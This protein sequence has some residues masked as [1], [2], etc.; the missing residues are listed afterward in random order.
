MNRRTVGFLLGGLAVALVLAFA[1]SRYASSEP[2]GLERVAAD[3][4][5]D[6]DEQPHT[7]AD[8]PFAGYATRGIGDE[9]TSTGVAGIV[10][11]LVTFATAGGL[12][13]LVTVVARSR[14]SPGDGER[15]AA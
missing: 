1:V 8:G 6:A 10:G 14:T 7:L 15:A 12:V 13:A 3:H 5:I 9:G 11:V 2:D 4:A